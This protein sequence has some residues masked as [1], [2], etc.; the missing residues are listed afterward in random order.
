MT[1]RSLLGVR[2][3]LT[4]LGL[5]SEG[6]K[7]GYIGYSLPLN[8]R[9]TRLSANALFGDVEVIQG[10]SSE[11]DIQGDSSYYVLRLD[12]PVYADADMKWT[13]YGEWNRQKSTT[14]FFGVTI[15]DVQI[16]TWRSGFEVLLLGNRT[17]FYTTMGVGHGT[18]KEYTFGEEWTQNICSGNAFWRLQLAEDWR[19]SL[20]GAW[21][22]VLG[23]DPLS[24]SQYFYLGHTS[25]VRGYENDVISAEQGAYVNAQ[26]DWSVAGP[27]TSLFAFFDAGKLGGT[28][29]YEQRELASVG[30]G[31]TWPLW[32]DA[33][34]TGTVGIPL[35]RDLDEGMH[36]NKARFDLAVVATW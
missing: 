36:V 8:S 14:D 26:I 19:L 23:G 24:T 7:S 9:G 1:N 2:D 30:A 29:S 18:V 31:L 4:V 35:I 11:Q 27:G 10:V 34:L 16:D 6:S 25:G 17:V 12:H 13:V 3:N 5:A 20:S 28:S 22:A 15:N 32:R 33:S 21:Q